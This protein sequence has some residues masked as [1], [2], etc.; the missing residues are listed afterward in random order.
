MEQA[1]MSGVK[2]RAA[3]ELYA[4]HTLDR[5]IEFVGQFPTV[6]LHGSSVRD[7]DQGLK[8]IIDFVFAFLLL[9][10]L[11]P[12]LVFIAVAILIDSPG[13]AVPFIRAYWPETPNLPLFQI[14]H[15]GERCIRTQSGRNSF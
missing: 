1:E 11:S 13:P 5:P 10:I 12:I 6:P 2:L 14:P 15:Y 9:L 7:I 3:P 4:G 8:R